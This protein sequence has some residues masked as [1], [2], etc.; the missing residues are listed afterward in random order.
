MRELR[1]SIPFVGGVTAVFTQE[2]VQQKKENAVKHAKSLVSSTKA[3]TVMGIGEVKFQYQKVLIFT[4]PR[5][6]ALGEYLE[7]KIKQ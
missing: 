4:A 1:L 5:V 2:E 6:K 7:S 3:L